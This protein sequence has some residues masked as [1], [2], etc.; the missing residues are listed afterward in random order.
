MVDQS[1]R[2]RITG[3]VLRLVAVSD[4]HFPIGRNGIGLALSHSFLKQ[5]SYNFSYDFPVR[6]V[7]FV[8]YFCHGKVIG[9]AVGKLV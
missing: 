7:L 4:A 8:L 1:V 6:D 2:V 9:K 3:D 5:F